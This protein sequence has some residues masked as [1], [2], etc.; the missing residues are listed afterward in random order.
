MLAS[1]FAFFVEKVFEIRHVGDVEVTRIQRKIQKIR[2]CRYLHAQLINGGT[3]I[4]R[5]RDVFSQK[6]PR[7]TV[8]TQKMRDMVCSCLC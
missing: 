2:Y 6:S 3:C 8:W 4:D 5:V 1:Q 7:L